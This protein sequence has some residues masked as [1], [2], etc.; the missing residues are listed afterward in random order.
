[1]QKLLSFLIISIV[2][3]TIYLVDF[4]FKNNKRNYYSCFNVETNNKI[5]LL[6]ETMF[7]EFSSRINDFDKK[8]ECKLLKYTKEEVKYNN[9]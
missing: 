7:Y 2:F 1:M 6:N 5:K 9:L 8:Y 4:D 3:Y